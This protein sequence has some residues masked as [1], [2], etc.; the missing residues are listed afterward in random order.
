MIGEEMRNSGDEQR[1]LINDCSQEIAGQKFCIEKPRVRTALNTS[2][3]LLK[4][5]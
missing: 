3:T 4:S 5:I 2:S 1:N